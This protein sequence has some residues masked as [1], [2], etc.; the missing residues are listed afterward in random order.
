MQEY[1]ESL[2]ERYR[3]LLR[4]PPGAARRAH[5]R[6][7]SLAGPGV[8]QYLQSTRHSHSSQCPPHS[9]RR[10][11]GSLAEYPGEVIRGFEEFFRN[12]YTS[13]PVDVAG[14]DS[15]LDGL[16]TLSDVDR[17][18]LELPLTIEELDTAV[19]TAASG[20]SPGPDGLPVEFYVTFWPLLRRF[21]LGV[22]QTSLSGE[23]FPESFGFG[24]IIV[25]PK[26]SGDHADPENWRPITLLNCDYK[27]L[28]AILAKRIQSVLPSVIHSSQTCG[29]P[30][31]SMY[32]TLSGLRDILRYATATSV[33]SRGCLLSL[34]QAKAFDGVEHAYM[35]AV[36]QAYGFPSWI[37]GVIRRLYNHHRSRIF[38]L[39][40]FSDEFTVTRRVR[41]GCPLSPALFTLVID[42]LLWAIDTDTHIH[43]IPL[44]I[45]GTWKV[46]AY[47][48]DVT[49]LL[50]DAG[51]V[52]EVLRVYDAYAV[53]SGE[54]LNYRKTKLMPLGDWAS[55]LLLPFS[56]ATSL[57]ILGVVFDRHG[58]TTSNWTTALQDLCSRCK[59]SDAYA[60]SYL[61]C[62]S[63]S[64]CLLW[65]S[66]L[67]ILPFCPS[68]GGSGEGG[69]ALPD[70]SLMS[71]GIALNTVLQIL[72]GEPSPTQVLLKYWM[73]PLARDLLPEAYDPSFPAAR[74][75][76]R[77][78]ATV[79]AYRRKLE[80]LSVS[81]SAPS[82]MSQAVLWSEV[83]VSANWIGR[84]QQV[85]TVRWAS[86]IGSWLPAPLR[87]VVWNFAWGIHPTRDRLQTWNLT[88]T[89]NCVETNYHVLFDCRIA[90][91]SWRH[92]NII[93][94]VPLHRRQ[95]CH[96]I[97]ALL[98][99][100]GAQVLW[101]A[102]CKAVAQRLRNIPV[103]LLVRKLRVSVVAILQQVL[104]ALGEDGFWRRWRDH[105]S[106]V[107][108][109]AYV[110]IVG[111][112]P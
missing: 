68:F 56:C 86:A 111:A 98:T 96:R 25:L 2:R 45:S 50:R 40:R 64:E 6:A 62:I 30:G 104:F 87:D 92:T 44:P 73:G 57:K 63:G 7:Q 52:D 69:L 90:R 49:V 75:P 8:V 34:D 93:C 19:T 51:S 108:Q 55:Y 21:F 9:L 4:S 71:K 14:T 83:Q 20:T 39:H 10:R 24:H 46:A 29:V 58:P 95:S 28:T 81:V 85:R 27:F 61:A 77:F 100:C 107:I 91:I 41:Q 59:A 5:L 53:I 48:D 67:L 76:Q 17:V 15:F 79:H 11:D 66:Y 72:R 103:F 112:L 31:R 99:A 80:S 22:L 43:G 105:P 89:D 109:D 74:S 12:L 54:L 70:M 33:P 3:L 18:S 23:P 88:P 60:L 84:L 32:G 106:V 97:S 36:L 47:A 16:L 102:R 26:N 1:L 94:P 110:S 82:R 37:C 65:P 78:H 101:A 35:L 38:M 13:C 42:P